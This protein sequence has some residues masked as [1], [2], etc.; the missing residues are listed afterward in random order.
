M[1][2]RRFQGLCEPIWAGIFHD[3]PPPDFTGEDSL[4]ET[5]YCNTPSQR[6]CRTQDN[7]KAAIRHLIKRKDMRIGMNIH[8]I[9]REQAILSVFGRV[10]P[11]AY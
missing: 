5:T 7:R 2:N 4:A 6:C 8:S 11:I 10:S 9:H 1:Q 3:I